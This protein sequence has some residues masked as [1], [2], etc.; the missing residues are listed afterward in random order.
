M[1]RDFAANS[2]SPQGGFAA[3]VAREDTGPSVRQQHTTNATTRA[4][5]AASTP[6]RDPSRAKR[7]AVVAAASAAVAV[8]SVGYGVWAGVSSRAATEAVAADLIPTAV[9]ATPIGAGE[10]IA[11]E[12]IEVVDVPQLFRSEGALDAVSLPQ[13]GSVI[14]SKALVD[15]PAGSQIVPGLVAGVAG[16]DRLAAALASGTEAVTVA[17]DA[18]TGLAGQ[19]RPFDTVRVLSTETAASGEVLLRTVCERALVVAAGSGS[20]DM[21]GGAVTLAVL[22]EEANAIREAQFAGRVSF[23]LLALV[24]APLQEAANG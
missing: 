21:A 12:Q 20:D 19:I 18:E 13:G 22:P 5:A 10:T 9:A 3:R 7:L 4:S 24:D 11:E 23:V 14:G 15:I 1:M 8:A 6:R 17:V 16:G 2:T